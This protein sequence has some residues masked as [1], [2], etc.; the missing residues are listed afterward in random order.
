MSPFR[1]RLAVQTSKCLMLICLFTCGLLSFRFQASIL[2]TLPK[3]SSDDVAAISSSCY[4]LN[5]VQ[6]RALLEQYI[7][8]RGEPRVAPELIQ[9]AVIVAQNTADETVLKEGQHITLLEEPDLQLPFLLPEDGFSCEFVRGVTH[10]M[11]DFIEPLARAG[12]LS[13]YTYRCSFEIE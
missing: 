8:S 7:P 9:G 10:E 1:R 2:L 11:V 5:S 3:E 12:W 4:R 13:H 6:L